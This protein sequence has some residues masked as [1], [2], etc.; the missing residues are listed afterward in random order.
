MDI[1]VLNKSFV[2]IGLIDVVD[3]ILW[4]ERYSGYGEF[5][6]YTPIT[7]D[8]LN[9]LQEDYYIQIPNS[10]RTMIIESLEIKTNVETGNKLVVR[11]RS[12]E[13]ILERRI[14]W[15]QMILNQGLQLA[16]Q[17]IITE[18]FIT[19]TPGGTYGDHRKV[20][21]L[22]FSISS[23]T[24]VTTPNVNEQYMSNNVYDVI[25]TLCDK[26][27]VGF[28]LFLTASN[29]LEFKLYSG[30]DRSYT[31]ST[32]SFVVFSPNFDNLI[33]SDYFKTGRNRK[34]V[35]FIFGYQQSDGQLIVTS[36]GI[37]NYTTWPGL[38]HREVYIDASSRVNRFIE[39]TSTPIDISVFVAQ[40]QSI[41]LNEL[42]NNHNYIEVF[43]GQA[44]TT[45][46]FKYG[47]DF[48][49]GDIV[50]IENEY[51]MLGKSRIT[52]IT[53]SENPSG[54]FIYPTFDKIA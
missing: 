11:G 21:N 35:A 15:T 16:I 18:A 26:N 51:G 49:L 3:S 9:L 4:V 13:S 33:S 50:Q 43:D 22:T 36:K 48:F 52:E 14:I 2:A 40:L 25:K 10:S 6:I 28:R 5:E 42:L 12:L 24:N 46:S 30:I 53:F 20:S 34:T 32:N 39:G 7:I 44:D 23:D 41:G 31:Q 37:P 1:T 54:S 27:T 47:V 45:N 29:N 17:N 8:L 38:D 19:P